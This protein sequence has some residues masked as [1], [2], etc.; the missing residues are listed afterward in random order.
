MKCAV[1]PPTKDGMNRGLM[2]REAIASIVFFVLAGLSFSYWREQPIW[3]N[4]WFPIVCDVC[5]LNFL[6]RFWM[7]QANVKTPVNQKT[8]LMWGFVKWVTWLTLT[9]SLLLSAMYYGA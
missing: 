5:M 9:G 2:I 3:L 6:S 4:P 7:R 1:S 8:V